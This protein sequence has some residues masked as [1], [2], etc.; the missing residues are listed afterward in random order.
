MQL[1]IRGRR[2]HM[3]RLLFRHIERQLDSVLSHFG[4]REVAWELYGP[5][6]DPD[7]RKLEIKSCGQLHHLELMK[8]YGRSV[9]RSIARCKATGT[10]RVTAHLVTGYS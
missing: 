5:R 1:D 4:P 2:V 9:A 7:W 10:S 6:L 8:S 3:T